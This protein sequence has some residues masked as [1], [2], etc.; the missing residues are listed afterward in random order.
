M[1]EDRLVVGDET[2][3]MV[4]AAWY[5]FIGGLNQSEVAD[6]L[7]LSRIK[8]NRLIAQAR[9]EGHVHIRITHPSAR[10][11]DI[12]ARLAEAY[13]LPF[14]R[15]VPSLAEGGAATGD[16]AA[17][18]RRAVGIAAADVLANE[19]SRQPD[20]IFG[21]GWGNTVAD[22][23]AQFAGVEAPRAKFVSVMGSLT[24]NAASNPLESVHRL[25]ELT[26]GEGYFLPAPY[27][28]D[29]VEDK[30]VFLA[31]RTVKDTLA[32]AARADL[33][34]VG[35][36]EVA[37]TSFLLTQ[38]LLTADE[39]ERARL[40]GAVGSFTGLFFDAQGRIVECD[41]NDRRIG[42]EPADLKK[43][44][45]IA[46]ASGAEKEAAVKGALAGRFFAGLVLDEALAR[47]LLPGGKA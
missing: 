41:V 46:V 31:Q 35:V 16:I 42:L 3:N 36:S 38:R 28:A 7:G 1:P 12:E 22:M 47:A 21:I 23:V 27:M 6:R 26:G 25:A 24:R 14:C 9:A 30:K 37:S 2:E 4:R 20:G 39:H 8:V 45:V 15:V 19:V 33:C 5:Y 17:A 11:L 18:D 44:R 10:I 32:L 34:L 29:T 40:A 43:R 13:K